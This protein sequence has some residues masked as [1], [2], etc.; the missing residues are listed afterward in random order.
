[1]V[2]PTAVGKTALAIHLA[3]QFGGE[4]INADSRQVYVGMD[5][6]TAKPTAEAQAAARHHLID[7]C[8]PATP[9][10]LGEFIPLAVKTI[11]EIAGRGQLPILCGGTGQ[12]VWALLE[13]WDVPSVLPDAE[14][15]KA[16]EQRARAEGV[17]ALWLELQEVDPVRAE[18]I[19]PNNLR[20]LIRALEI[21][22]NSNGA[23]ATNGKATSPPYNVLIIGLE[24][25]RAD[26]YRRID[27]RVDW[28][29]A[30]GLLDEAQRLASEGYTLG[31]GPLSGVGYDQLGQYLSNNMTLD[32]AVAQTKTRTHRLVRRQNTWFKRGDQRITWLDTTGRDPAEPAAAAV[33]EFLESSGVCGTIGRDSG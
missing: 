22:R 9:F 13:G 3:R 1:M 11:S 5:I 4:V 2:G 27:D 31:E 12:Y 21:R 19:G 6:G 32:E 10:S 24:A 29:M 7:I 16:M 30:N 33:R 17:Q 14:F 26:L 18:E 20:R 8:S 25:D 28:M 15:R 23:M